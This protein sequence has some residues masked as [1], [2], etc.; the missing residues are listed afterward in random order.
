M[1]SNSLGARIVVIAILVVLSFVYLLPIYVL[2]VTSLK[3]LQEVNQGKATT[4]DY[5]VHGPVTGCTLMTRSV[6]VGGVA[7]LSASSA[8]ASFA[9]STVPTICTRRPIQVVMST[10][11]KR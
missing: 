11:L 10:P 9:G 1:R 5:F 8:T 7:G 6:G 3:S 4:N 2:V